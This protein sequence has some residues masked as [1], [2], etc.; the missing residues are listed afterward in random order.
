MPAI[1][2]VAVGTEIRERARVFANAPKFPILA[3]QAAIAKWEYIVSTSQNI[4]SEKTAFSPKPSQ[5]ACD[6]NEQIPHE[7]M[8]S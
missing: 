6:E 8:L 7:D 5:T 1:L 2:R 4:R 3:Y